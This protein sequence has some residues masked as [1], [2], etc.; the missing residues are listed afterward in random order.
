[1]RTFKG[2]EVVTV[3][4]ISRKKL[5]RAIK[6]GKLSLSAADLK[7]DRKMLFHPS[8]AKLVRAAKTKG[9]GITGLGLSAP[10]ILS[11]IEWHDSMGGG[12][13]GGSLWSWVKGAASSVG[14]FFKDNWDVIKPVISRVADV[15]I[16]ALATALG[17][18]ELAGIARG[19]LKQLTGVGI[20]ERRLAN[21]AKA[22]A[23]KKS[24]PAGGSFL[25]N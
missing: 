19:G 14:K 2:Y 24:K 1:M 16:P 21:L 25:L 3:G 18:P 15:G 10:E 22:R 17:Q 4:D 12:M 20:K 7:G 6:T 5:E 11:D 13:N 23:A 8:S 9:K